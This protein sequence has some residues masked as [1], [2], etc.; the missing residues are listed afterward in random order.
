SLLL[1]PLVENAINHGLFHRKEGGKLILKFMQG[2]VTDE[3][4]CIIDDNGVGREK[5]K[6]I[7]SAS[8]IKYESYGTK[9]TKQLIDVFAEF[10]KMGITLE[11]IDKQQPETGTIVKLTIKNIKYVA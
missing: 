9:L 10:E 2:T 6:E 7:K 4:I 3:L 5:A 1:Q 8:G 11:Y